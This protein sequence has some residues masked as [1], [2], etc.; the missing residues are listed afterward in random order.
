MP[1]RKYEVG[2]LVIICTKSLTSFGSY[3]TV[4]SLSFVYIC[5]L[6]LI[7]IPTGG[8]FDGI[9]VGGI[10]LSGKSSIRLLILLFIR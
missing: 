2:D 3:N 7:V 8:N 1:E 10:S 9:T 5:F 4:E 6:H